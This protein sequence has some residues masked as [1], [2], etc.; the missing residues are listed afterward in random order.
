MAATGSDPDSSGGGGLSPGSVRPVSFQ[1]RINGEIDEVVIE[2]FGIAKHAFL[3]ESEALRDAAA[4]DVLR[5]AAQYHT[6][7]FLFVERKLDQARCRAS[8]DSQALTIL[9]QPIA[10]FGRAV[11][12]I[13]L[14]LS[15]NSCKYA[16]MKNPKRIAIV[17]RRFV[18]YR[19]DELQRIDD[20]SCV[21]KPWQPVAEIAPVLV[22]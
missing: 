22:S 13:H 19:V 21:V 2:P 17:P 6:V 3:D 11:C 10:R 16:A 8:H 4:L 15:N 20:G 12:T 1:H 7:A 18:G 9:I 14:V 5:G